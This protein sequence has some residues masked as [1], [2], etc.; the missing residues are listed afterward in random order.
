MHTTN[1]WWHV[2]CPLFFILSNEIKD[3]LSVY[4]KSPV[5]P[6]LSV[7]IF[8]V[9]VVVAVAAAAAATAVVAHTGAV[10]NFWVLL[11]FWGATIEMGATLWSAVDSKHLRARLATHWPLLYPSLLLSPVVWWWYYSANDDDDDN[12]NK[13]GNNSDN[14]NTSSAWCW[15]TFGPHFVLPQQNQIFCSVSAVHYQ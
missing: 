9:A 7:M 2:I 13:S 5:W 8:S 12:N 15:Y 10:C 4:I 6:I 14:D 1:F 3:V 11:D